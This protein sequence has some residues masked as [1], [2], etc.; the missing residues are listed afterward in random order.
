MD[1]LSIQRDILLKVFKHFTTL[2]QIIYNFRIRYFLTTKKLTRKTKLKKS[3]IVVQCRA[4]CSVRQK[5]LYL[6]SK[7]TD[8]LLSKS[9]KWLLRTI[10]VNRPCLSI[11]AGVTSKVPLLFSKVSAYTDSLPY[12]FIYTYKRT[13]NT[14]VMKMY[15]II[16]LEYSIHKRL[17]VMSKILIAALQFCFELQVCT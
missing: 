3:W 1:G 5:R 10:M 2:L 15:T 17:Q 11:T 6:T 12:I 13:F 16:T 8:R 7:R 14:S 4:R 9:N